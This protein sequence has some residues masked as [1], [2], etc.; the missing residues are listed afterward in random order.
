MAKI[1]DSPSAGLTSFDSQLNTI[2]VGHWPHGANATRKNPG[3][4]RVMRLP[5]GMKHSKGV[6]MRYFGLRNVARK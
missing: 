6:P 4:D 3:A 1:E 5:N 2:P